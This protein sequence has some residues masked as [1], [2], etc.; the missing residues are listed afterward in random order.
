MISSDGAIARRIC[1]LC[2]WKLTNLNLQSML[3]ICHM[4]YMV[5]HKG[6]PLLK[7]PFQAWIYGPVSP[8]IFRKLQRFG[9][10]PVRDRFYCSEPIEDCHI[11]AFLDHIIKILSRCKYYKLFSVTRKGAWRKNYV[12]DHTYRIPNADILESGEALFGLS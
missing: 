3:Y 9:N 10:S 2:D 11:N 12:S 1:E 6:K 7:E 5:K 4:I 8:V